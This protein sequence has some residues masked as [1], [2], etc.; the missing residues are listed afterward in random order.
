MPSGGV[1]SMLRKAS[2]MKSERA[3]IQGSLS[4]PKTFLFHQLSHTYEIKAN[5]IFP[6][7]LQRPLLI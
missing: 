2:Q 4:L 6:A 7:R 5:Q 1:Y 3:G